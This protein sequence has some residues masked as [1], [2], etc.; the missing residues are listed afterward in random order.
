VIVVGLLEAAELERQPTFHG[1]GV[2]VIADMRQVFLQGRDGRCPTVRLD[3]CLGREIQRVGGVG[4][5][6]QAA[7]RR[8]GGS[9]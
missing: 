1:A 5:E 9:D 3:L 6:P 2:G 7:T 4:P 8:R